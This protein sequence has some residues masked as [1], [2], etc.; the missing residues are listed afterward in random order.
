MKVKCK[1]C[2]L[3]LTKE[4]KELNDL[5]QIS[6]ID[7]E[8]YLPRGF[9]IKISESNDDTW[10]EKKGVIVNLY[11]I[12]NL[13]NHSDPSRLNG[14][15]GLDGSDGMNKVCLNGHE[16]GTE[17]SDCWMPRA[18]IFDLE[19]IKIHKKLFDWI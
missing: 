13:Q 14:C 6:S 5:D 3:V 19:K 12:V 2:G 16:V 1:E 17:K 15:C 8:N 11:D 18:M 9:Y 10:L 7:K 4:L